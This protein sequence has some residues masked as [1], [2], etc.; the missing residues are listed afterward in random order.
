MAIVTSTVGSS[1]RNYATLALWLASLPSNI[2]TSGNSYVASLYNDSEFVGSTASTLITVA[3][4]TTDAS[5]FL[6]ITAA[7]GQSWCDS[8]SSI[9][10]Y[11]S[12]QGVG[13]RNTDHRGTALEVDTDFTVVTRLQISSGQT[14]LV[15]PANNCTVTNNIAEDYN[16]SNLIVIAKSN[17]VFT[18]NVFVANSFGGNVFIIGNPSGGGTVINNNTF[19]RPSTWTA[20]GTAISTGYSYTG[21]FTNNAFFG[22]T[23]VS[24]A[25]GYTGSNNATDQSSISGSTSNLT[26]LTYSSQFRVNVSTGHDFRLATSGSSLTTGGISVATPTADAFGTAQPQSGNYSLGAFQI[27][28][29]PE[30]IT[31]DKWFQPASQPQ[32]VRPEMIPY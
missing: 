27:I 4:F 14:A 29:S 28:P 12:S 16:N 21:T 30:T 26:S 6:T 10:G 18:N 9:G 5:H 11:A 23:T 24:S 7:A 3:G 32:L 31:L 25:S 19:V 15:F 20:A 1:G 8:T 13:I 17:N 2:V 22:F